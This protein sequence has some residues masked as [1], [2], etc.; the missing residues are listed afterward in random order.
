MRRLALIAL[1]FLVLSLNGFAAAPAPE[2]VLVHGAL[3]TGQ[4]WIKVQEE[5]KLLG[6][7]SLAVDLPGRAGDR[8]PPAEINLHTAVQKLCAEL[9]RLPAPVT[10]VGHS[11]GGAVITQALA[12]CPARIKALVY[13]AAVV[14]KNGELPFD[15]LSQK[16]NEMFERCATY[17]EPAKL[18]RVNFNG[19]LWQAFMGDVPK[20]EADRW[21][22]TMVSEPSEIGGTRLEYPVEAFERT[23]KFYVE[24]LRDLI[25]S[26]ETQQKI[27]QGVVFRKTYTL[28]ASHSPFLSQPRAVAR[29]L[30]EA[31][32][33][34]GK[35]TG[36][37]AKF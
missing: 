13:I 34:M 29:I 9:K 3:F 15:R 7:D 30:D 37:S 26:K 35:Y 31:C 25:I 17:D 18:Y 2:F 36:N 21:T 27:R 4:G 33:L 10:L 6:H 19:P 14:P 8:T 12:A 16:D 24:T 1:S 32:R 28:D 22:A 11:Q 23:P 5:L 20:V